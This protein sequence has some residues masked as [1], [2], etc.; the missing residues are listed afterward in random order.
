M[1]DD[2]VLIRMGMGIIALD[3]TLT[4]AIVIAKVQLDP[5]AATLV[6]QFNTLAGMVIG[7]YY[8]SSKGSSDKTQ[9]LGSLVPSPDSPPAP[10]EGSSTDKAAQ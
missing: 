3:F 10:P 2:S 4:V 9:I 7:Y 8:G 6:G 1:K 5:T